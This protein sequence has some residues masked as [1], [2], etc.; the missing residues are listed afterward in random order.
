MGFIAG[1]AIGWVLL[2]LAVGALGR[3]VAG[4]VP[5]SWAGSLLAA[6][7]GAL[8]GGLVAAVLR[9]GTDPYSPAGWIVAIIAAA[10]SLAAY[11]SAVVVRRPV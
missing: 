5:M 1:T 9:L 8:A 6:I 4:H 11:H 3:L 2:G 10:L 7:A